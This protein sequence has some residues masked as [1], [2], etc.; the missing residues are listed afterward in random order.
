VSH[1]HEKRAHNLDLAPIR[2]S[3]LCKLNDAQ[4]D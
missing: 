4:A 2:E 1:P 3:A